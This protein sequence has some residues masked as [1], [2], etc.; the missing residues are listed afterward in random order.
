MTHRANARSA[1]AVV[2]ALAAVASVAAGCGPATEGQAQQAYKG[3]RLYGSDGNMSNS[4]GKVFTNQPGLLNGMKGTTPLTPVPEEFKRRVKA[5]DGQLGDFNYAG[6]AYDAVV[7]AVLAAEAARSTEGAQIAR[8]IPAVTVARGPTA[9]PCETVKLC[10]DA[11][12]A[13]KDIAFRG[14]SLRR[15]G[16]TD[17]GEPTT[18]SYGTLTFSRDNKIDD[19]KTEFI[20]AGDEA[21]EAK[22]LP[23]PPANGRPQFPRPPALKVG[24]VLPKTGD[25]AGLGPP[26]FAGA[27]LAVRE[28]NEAGGVLGLPVQWVDGDDGTNPSVAISTVD[29]HIAAGVQVM[30]GAGASDVTKAVLP[31]AAAAGRVL[32]SPTS[33]SDELTTID[34]KGFFFRTAPPDTLQAKALVDVIMRY[35]PERVAIV[36]QDGSYGTG[37]R[38]NVAEGLRAAGLKPDRIRSMGYQRRDSYDLGQF[39]EIAAAVSDFRPEAV[40]V[41]GTDESAN[42]IKALAAKGVRFRD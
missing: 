18:A 28:A 7:L 25:A 15:S 30:I 41:I 37:L 16:L 14:I 33:T 26:I 19:A 3:A 9:T 29:R 1:A 4:L 27:Q 10:L 20:G 38:N 36:A 6:E 22:E 32:I 42:V 35:G 8:F 12:R 17:R 13:G 5:I 24:A 31:K 23:V 39:A 40:L 21:G 2:A 11:I 34:D